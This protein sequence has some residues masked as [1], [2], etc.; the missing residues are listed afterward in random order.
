MVVA[1]Q[2]YRLRAVRVD[3]PSL[4]LPLAGTK[5]VE[6][7]GQQSEI[8]AGQFLMIHHATCLQVENL[9][10]GIGGDSYRA[11]AIALPWRVVELARTL[12]HAHASPEERRAALPFSTGSVTPLLPWLQHLLELLSASATPDA[13]LL[14]HGLLGVALALA[15]AGHGHF[16]HA[17]DPS[18]SARIRLL[19]AAAPEREWSSADFE[20]RL[21]M[22]GATLR[23]RLA[24]E[25]TSLRLLLREARLHHGLA[26]LQ[27]TRKPVKSV[28]QACG[29]RSVPSFTRNFVAHFGIEPSAVAHS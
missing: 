13:A 24:E 17:G 2:A 11:W 18:L 15:R 9:P 14:D 12:L 8:V 26:L 22:S 5:R 20:A 6:L 7:G 28:A 29:Y 10:T 23:R 25:N 3:L 27:T 1:Q 21:H 16:L 4:I 19:V